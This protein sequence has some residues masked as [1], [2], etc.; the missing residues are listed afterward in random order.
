MVCSC[1]LSYKTGSL[2]QDATLWVLYIFFAK[3][4]VFRAAICHCLLWTRKG[5]LNL[6]F[7]GKQR[8]EAPPRMRHH[9]FLTSDTLRIHM[10][11]DAG[12]A[13]KNSREE[14][15]RSPAQAA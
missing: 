14:G 10:R 4:C 7:L 8:N 15:G 6:G 12:R 9:L 13:E 1:S 2:G 5:A 11:S 3:L